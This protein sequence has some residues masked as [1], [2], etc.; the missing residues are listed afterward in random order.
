MIVIDIVDV[1]IFRFNLANYKKQSLKDK[2]RAV[3]INSAFIRYIKER[4]AEGLS[5]DTLKIEEI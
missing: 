3:V 1:K 2:I 4:K 5:N